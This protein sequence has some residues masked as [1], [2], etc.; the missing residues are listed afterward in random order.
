MGD[1]KE[2]AMLEWCL[3]LTYSGMTVD[4]I[5]YWM[6]KKRQELLARQSDVDPNLPVKVGAEQEGDERGPI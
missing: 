3:R 6:L 2:T 5:R 4:M 1:E